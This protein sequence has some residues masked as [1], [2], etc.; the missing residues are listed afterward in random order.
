MT[1]RR[2]FALLKQPF[3]LDALGDVSTGSPVLGDV[4]YYDGS[5][6]TNQAGAT[7][8]D[9]NEVITGTWTFSTYYNLTPSAAPAHS[10]GRI[11]YDSTSKALS[12]YNE[13]ADVTVNLGQENIVR[14]RN[15]TGSTI[16]NGQAVY[17][18]GSLGAALPTVALAQADALATSRTIGL[19]THDIENNTTGYV[20][21]LGLVNNLDTSGFSA[22]DVLYLSTSTAG[23]LVNTRPTTGFA[24]V[25]GYCTVS[26]VSV[27]QIKV[28]PGITVQRAD[29]TSAS[30]SATITGS[31]DFT[32]APQIGGVALDEYVEDTAGGMA[33]NG[34]GVDLT[35]DDGAGTL[36]ASLNINGLTAD[37]SPVGSTDY[38]VTYDADAATHKKVLLDNLP[39]GASS[40]LTTKGDIWGYS[41]VDARV[42]VGTNGHVLTADSAEALGVKWAA[43]AATLGDADYGDIT[44]SSSGTV[45]TID[46]N[47]VTY[48]KMQDVSATSRILGRKTAGSGDTEE[49]TLSEILDFV[50]SAAQGD[51][52]YRGASGWTRL[53]AGTSGQYLK[54]QGSGADPVWGTVSGGSGGPTM[55]L[56]TSDESRNTTTTLTDDSTLVAT[57]SANTNYVFE[58]EVFFVSAATPD[59]KFALNF[60]GTTT[61]A[62]S[63]YQYATSTNTGSSASQ[64]TGLRDALVPSQAILTGS[65]RHIL[66]VRGAIQVGGSGGTLSFQWAQNT[67]NA[68]DTTVLAGSWLRTIAV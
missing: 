4:L 23:G 27:G 42:P 20:C 24:A 68:T 37:A 67:S 15:T 55:A 29:V 49:C 54:T 62:D 64:N 41:T 61:R 18:N 28:Q 31:W 38:I 19:A 25:V 53:A 30:Q 35:Y 1:Q 3:S 65:D 56:K 57:L 9:V 5:V 12:Y 7:F 10:E 48:A 50:G 26:N 6:W 36:T 32:T 66:Q 13:E 8:D 43:V 11:W 51:I 45:M 14:V 52:L 44:V 46:N 22:G 63:W 39:S 17:I 58:F 2:R 47:V 34:T 16:T 21:T 33:T 40:P 59:F 60:T